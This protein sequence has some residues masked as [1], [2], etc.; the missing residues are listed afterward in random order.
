[1]LCAFTR[2]STRAVLTNRV[3]HLSCSNFSSD[4]GTVR[5]RTLAELHSK[6]TVGDL[7]PYHTESTVGADEY[8]EG[9]LRRPKSDLEWRQLL[10]EQA[11]DQQKKP[12]EYHKPEFIHSATVALKSNAVNLPLGKPSESLLAIDARRKAWITYSKLAG[13]KNKPA[14]TASVQAE[15][16]SWDELCAEME[17]LVKPEMPEPKRREY[18]DGS[19][20]VVA[21]RRRI[22][23]S[24]AQ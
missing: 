24:R 15:P 13:L 21:L 1:M 2:R 3:V 22:A 14:Q 5:D 4:G 23:A 10:G 11:K 12:R 19:V 6:H 18:S 9:V 17:R 16:M 7:E 20:D 8:W